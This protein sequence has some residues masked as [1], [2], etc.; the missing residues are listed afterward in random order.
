M[1]SQVKVHI[2]HFTTLLGQM[3]RHL[4]E[5]EIIGPMAQSKFEK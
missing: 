4:R 3:V 5:K 2:L 1:R